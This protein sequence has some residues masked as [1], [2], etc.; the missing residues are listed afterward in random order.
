MIIP[1]H[2]LYAYNMIFMLRR[3]DGR[4]GVHWGHTWGCVYAEDK[5][6]VPIRYYLAKYGRKAH[7]DPDNM[8]IQLSK[9]HFES[10]AVLDGR[11]MRRQGVPDSR[12]G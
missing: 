1:G 10:L 6:P 5:L 9:E 12:I 2:T 11:P 7:P 4:W 3:E 8:V